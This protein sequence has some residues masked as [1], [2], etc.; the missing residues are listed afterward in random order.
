M[1]SN[2]F[3]STVIQED[4]KQSILKAAVLSKTNT[5]T[6]LL[7]TNNINI[8]SFY[9]LDECGQNLLHICV[10]TKNYD[11]A[12]YLVNKK[13]DKQKRNTFNETPYDVAL[14]NWDL[15]MLEIL[16]E[17]DNNSFIKTE[18]RRLNDRV[19]ELETNNKR[20]IDTNKE[21]TQKNSVLHL[22]LDTEKRTTKRLRDD[23]D[24]LTSENK[25]MRL[26]NT[27]LKDDNKVMGDTIKTLR[28]SMKKK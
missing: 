8:N 27:K 15:K 13:I 19:S 22:Q 6:N 16:M 9:L 12:R 26:E 18:N 11:L 20:F 3:G 4:I 5:V 23:N 10:R 28:E 14:K 21:L 7:E 25:R 17:T 2:I 24:T 1:F